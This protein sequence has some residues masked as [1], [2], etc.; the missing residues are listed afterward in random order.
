MQKKKIIR[1]RMLA[2]AISAAMIFASTNTYVV[3]AEESGNLTV[4]EIGNIQSDGPEAEAVNSEEDSNFGD[5][6]DTVEEMDSAS[7]S[8]AAEETDS[9]NNLETTEET[10]TA[11][12]SEAAEEIDSASDPDVV[13][14]SGNGIEET[15][16]PS[17]DLTEETPESDMEETDIDDIELLASGDDTIMYEGTTNDISWKIT[18][19]GKLTIEGTGDYKLSD[20]GIPPWCNYTYR[21]IITS[22]EVNVTGITSTQAMFAYCSSMTSVDLSNLDTSKVTDMSKMFYNCTNLTGVDVS[23]FDTSK[24]T[25]MNE[26]FASCYALTEVDVSKFDTGKVTDMSN[27]FSLCYEL[28][29][30]DVS[31]FN[32]SKVTDMSWMFSG[33]FELTSLDVS[34]FNTSKV[35]D[36]SEMFSSC[37]K[38]TSLDVS[39]FD[40]RQTTKFA[41]MFYGCS[42]LASLDVSNFDTGNAYSFSSMFSGCSSLK[43]L[44][45]RGFDTSS[46]TVMGLMF[47]DCS[48]LTSL[49]VRGFDTSKVKTINEMFSGCSSLTSLDVS[50]FDT[51]EVTYAHHMFTN[52]SNLTSLNV[53]GFKMASNSDCSFKGMFSG[54]ESL[55]SLDVSSFDTYNMDNMMEM[56]KGCKSLTSLDLSS[57]R[58]GKVTDMRNMFQD[59]SSLVSLNVSGWDTYM[60][61]YVGYMFEGC[62]SLTG[63]DLSGFEL[64]KVKSGGDTMLSGCDSLSYIC[65]PIKCSHSITLPVSAATDKWYREDGSECTNLPTNLTESIALYKNGYPGDVSGETKK[66]AFV[67]GI[68]VNNKIYDKTPAAYEGT[69]VVK[70]AEGNTISGLWLSGC[71]YTGILADGSIYA[72][73]AE[74]PSQAG[75]YTLS[76]VMAGD[77]VD[78][79]NIQNTSYAFSIKPRTLTITAS[80]L[81][82]ETD[83]AVPALSEIRYTSEGLLEGEGLTTEPQFKYS[84]ENIDTSKAG[85]YKIIPYGADAGNNY[86]IRYINGTLTIGNPDYVP[87]ESSEDDSPYDDSQ[88]TDL[89]MADLNASISAVKAKTYDG[90][91]YEPT[92]K[93]TVTENKKKKTLTEGTDYRVL[94][95]NNINAGTEGKV[96]IRGNGIYKGELTKPF[97]IK[98]KSIKKLKVIAGSVTENITEADI[99]NGTVDLPIY[100]YDGR[101]LLTKG[102]DYNLTFKTLKAKTLT[103][104][105]VSAQGSNYTGTTTAKIT[106]YE[107]IDP[108]QIINP[109]NVTLDYTEAA[110]TGKAIKPGVTVKVGDVTLTNKNYK[111]QYQNNKNAGTAYVIVTGKGTYKGK[112]VV[113]FVI[114]PDKTSVL[115]ITNTIK[116]K[117]Y[118]GKLQK[119]SVTVK[120][121]KTKLKKNQDYTVS[122]TQN[123]HVG[124]ATVTVTGKGNYVGTATQTFTINPQKIS[125][126]SVKGTWKGGLTLTYGTRKLKPN[127]DYTVK[128]ES[129]TKNK[130]KVKITAVEGGDFTGSVTKTVKLK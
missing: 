121:G 17:D 7:G 113:P 60:L 54:C 126:I 69:P 125:K 130:A 44:D 14:E 100:V 97:T 46:A 120:V 115:Q 24:V 79:Y 81:A 68:T 98:P 5:E 92:V 108:S 2:F 9:G 122:Y 127:T 111:V 72:E 51:S 39:G 42:S 128:C 29:S 123:L 96:I 15:A 102:K 91:P 38:L 117:T 49:D 3:Q 6:L 10:D 53:C 94:Y 73:T 82:I 66:V 41:K 36:M 4:A 18:T 21:Q 103:L 12:G 95:E 22:A 50:S 11:S 27:M 28:T 110:Y 74:A 119:P 101:K 61:Q 112:A 52:C 124:T 33:C 58:T 118:N 57:F 88:R 35:T 56:F 34:R 19:R 77:S 85:R 75:N 1:K 59:C 32:T 105:I 76:I 87:P 8:E 16:Q 31:R 78:N 26:M 37:P 90:N 83:E 129:I 13:E 86:Q 107:G 62:H 93:V 45:V 63:L 65:A 70:D 109:A 40:T 47:K 20:T 99:A 106:I 67:S 25:D 89:G 84:V 43:N 30:L 23:K 71:S 114:T 80:S 48:S 104:N 55:T 64:P 116:A